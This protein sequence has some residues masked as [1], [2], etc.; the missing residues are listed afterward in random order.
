M[1]R[2]P[3]LFHLLKIRD[4]LWEAQSKG[5]SKYLLDATFVGVSLTNNHNRFRILY[6]GFLK[7][8]HWTGTIPI[9]KHWPFIGEFSLFF[10][11]KVWL[12]GQNRHRTWKQ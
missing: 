4:W 9:P 6:N 11:S 3:L 12:L 5:I 7:E 8:A 10:V 2:S 1:D